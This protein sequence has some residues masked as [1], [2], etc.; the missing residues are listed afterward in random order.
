MNDFDFYSV[1][2]VSNSIKSL[3]KVGKFERKSIKSNIQWGGKFP[4]T[5]HSVNI[6]YI[7]VMN[8]GHSE[9]SLRADELVNSLPK[10]DGVVYHIKFHAVD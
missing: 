8:I 1:S 2:A 10:I 5:T 9:A 4:K 3:M 7:D 6:G